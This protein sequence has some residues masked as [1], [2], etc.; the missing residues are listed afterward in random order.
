MR[1]LFRSLGVA[2]QRYSG[3]PNVVGMG[4]GYKKRGRQD[5]DELAIIFFVE[6]KVPAE[7]LGVDECV[8]KR[9]GRVCTDV[10][11]IGEVQFLGRTEK[12]RPAAPGSSI[13]HV[14]VTAGTFGAVVRDRKT[15]ELMILS[16]NHV[17]ANATDGLDGRARRGDL[18][19]QPGVYDGGSE[20]DVIGH[21]ERFVPI[22]RFSREADCNLAAMS[23]KAVNAVIHAFRPNYYVRLEKRGASNLVDCAL[24]RPVDPKEIIPEIIDIGKVNGVAQAEPGMAVKKSGR[25][26]GVTEGKITAVHVTLNVTMGRNTDVVRFQEQVMAELKSQAGDSGSLVLD[27]ENRAVGLLFAGSSEYTVF[28]PIEN[29]LNKLEVDLV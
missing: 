22:Y 15:G 20:E 26:T 10:I 25:T 4:I 8:P 27:R 28:N 3:L 5:T 23:V 12:M 11:E 9:I 2:E 7:A 14:K 21:L 17:L 18:I 6:K 1:K 19:L 13:G 16:N 24:A 29:V